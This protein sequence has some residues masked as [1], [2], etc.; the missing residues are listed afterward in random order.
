[1]LKIIVVPICCTSDWFFRASK[2]GLTKFDLIGLAVVV[3]LPA[4]QAI[5]D[6]DR[7]S[8]N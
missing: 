2:V 8:S 4:W 1:M 6:N 7:Y 5:F 3:M